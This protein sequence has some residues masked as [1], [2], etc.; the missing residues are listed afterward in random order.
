MTRLARGKVAQSYP[1]ATQAENTERSI[2]LQAVALWLVAALL[3]V[4]SL[5]VLGQRLARMSFLDCWPWPSRRCPGSRRPGPGPPRSCAVSSRRL[6][7]DRPP[8]LPASPWC[9]YYHQRPA[10]L[11]TGGQG[12]GV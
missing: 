2:H 12:P 3:A 8:A 10:C 7:G 6:P 4:I 5:L 9:A 1:L 11:P